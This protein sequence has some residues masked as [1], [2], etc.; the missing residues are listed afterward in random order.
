MMAARGPGRCSDRR[1]L[2]SACAAGSPPVAR[3]SAALPAPDPAASSAGR[4]P[5][6]VGSA[7][8]ALRHPPGGVT[9]RIYSAWAS[10]AV[11]VSTRSQGDPYRRGRVSARA[12]AAGTGLDSKPGARTG[13]TLGSQSG[14]FAPKSSG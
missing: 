10:A 11:A 4:L 9:A 1:S 14:S 6:T 5:A 2:V 12:A 3:T 8:R 13:D 7:R